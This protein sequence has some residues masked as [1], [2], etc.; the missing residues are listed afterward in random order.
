MASQP[1]NGSVPKSPNIQLLI[2]QIHGLEYDPHATKSFELMSGGFVWS[3]ESPQAYD[4]VASGYAFRFLL[5]YRTSLIMGKPQEALESVWNAVRTECPDWPGFRPERISIELAEE[6][7][8]AVANRKA[9]R[10]LHA[11]DRLC[12]RERKGPE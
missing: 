4:D 12:D 5:G 6:L 3:D 10:R 9:M 11:L 8:I 1:K 2:K 7:N